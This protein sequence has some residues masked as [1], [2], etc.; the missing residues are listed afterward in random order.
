MIDNF[1]TII[2]LGKRVTIAVEPTN[3]PL[4]NKI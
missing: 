4:D 1:L 3:L 2:I